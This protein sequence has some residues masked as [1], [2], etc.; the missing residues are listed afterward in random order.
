ME[1][2][3]LAAVGGQISR[4]GPRSSTGPLE[5]TAVVGTVASIRTILPVL[6]YPLGSVAAAVEVVPASVASLVVT[7]AV[8]DVVAAVAA[9]VEAG[10]GHKSTSGNR[11]RRTPTDKF[12]H[13]FLPVV[14][15]VPPISRVAVASADVVGAGAVVVA[16]AAAVAD[17]RVAAGGV[18][19]P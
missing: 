15:A 12:A 16:A 5:L 8:A 2:V 13:A 19:L 17:G 6:P 10:S 14:V 1:I 18:P 4:P 11:F 9:A 3:D 7:V